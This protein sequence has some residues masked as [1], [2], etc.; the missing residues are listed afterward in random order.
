MQNICKDYIFPSIVYSMDLEDVNN[1]CLIEDCLKIKESNESVQNSNVGG[2][3]SPSICEKLK[4][5]NLKTLEQKVEEAVLFVLNC[6]NLSGIKLKTGYWININ[7]SNDYNIIH[8]HTFP[9][10][11]AVY[12]PFVPKNCEAELVFNRTDGGCYFDLHKSNSIFS[13][14]CRTGML[15]IFSPHLFHYVLPNKSKENRISIAYNFTAIQNE[16]DD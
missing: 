15:I 2:W 7:S 10:I 3:Q 5:L 16:P 9:L 6:E 1:S 11:T 8:H 12:Y 13:I 14:S 4:T